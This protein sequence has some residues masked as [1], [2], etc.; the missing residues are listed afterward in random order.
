[1]A[2]LGPEWNRLTAQAGGNKIP[3]QQALMALV[4]DNYRVGISTSGEPYVKDRA[5][6]GVAIPLE[7]AVSLKDKLVADLYL[8]TGLTA[9]SEA[10]GSVLSMIRGMA[11]Q[12]EPVRPRLRTAR[13]SDGRIAIDLGRRDGSAVLCGPYGWE[14]CTRGLALFRRT[15]FTV[16]L[17]VP[18]RGGD[19]RPALGLINLRD[20]NAL[21]AYS[22]CRIMACMPGQTLPAE[23]LTGQP[24]TAKTG[25]T[26]LTTGWLGGFMAPMPKEL[27]DW[28]AMA[29]SAHALGA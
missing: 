8:L 18:V 24:G 21:A 19:A 4:T 27:K 3:A 15:D 17:P 22:A 29:N 26:R 16:P 10:I 25:T 7:G 5:V 14:I 13:L 12:A 20:H 1:M 11:T 2:E 6:P 28:A 23:I 9:S